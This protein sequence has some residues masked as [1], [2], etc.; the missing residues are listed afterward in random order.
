M[1]CEGRLLIQCALRRPQKAAEVQTGIGWHACRGRASPKATQALSSHPS[2]C[3]L[4]HPLLLPTGSSVSSPFCSP[5]ASWVLSAH[6]GPF[7]TQLCSLDGRPLNPLLVCHSVNA[8]KFSPPLFLTPF[9]IPRTLWVLS[10]TRLSSEA[11]AS[12]GIWV[13]TVR[14][15]LGEP[16]L[17]SGLSNGYC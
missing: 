17:P 9:C 12:S 4:S 11:L 3:S 2:S 5:G 6:N 13:V 10:N 7:A 15:Y 16:C 1:G 8:P 14:E